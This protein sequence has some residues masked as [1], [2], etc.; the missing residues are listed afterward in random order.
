[1][2]MMFLINSENYTGKKRFP[3]LT[4]NGDV[5]V[6]FIA[7][8]HTTGGTSAVRHNADG[9]LIASTLTGHGKVLPVTFLLTLNKAGT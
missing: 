2:I 1:M 9:H 6:C 3:D 4:Q 8:N 5:P 7:D